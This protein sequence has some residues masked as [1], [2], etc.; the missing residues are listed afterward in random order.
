M[1]DDDKP[2]PS[3]EPPKLFGR[4]RKAAEPSSDPAP[5]EASAP[6]DQAPTSAGTAPVA[7]P[8]TEQ[9]EAP[10]TPAP[11]PVAEVA[12]QSVPE[13]AAGLEPVTHPD[14]TP[15]HVEEPRPL[16]EDEVAAE[17]VLEEAPA[18]SDREERRSRLG[19]ATRVLPTVRSRRS[20][21][22]PDDTDEEGTEPLDDPVTEPRRRREGPPLTGRPAAAAVGFIAGGLA[23]LLTALSLRLCELVRGTSACGSPGFLLLALIFAAVVATGGYLLRFLRVPDPFSTSFL[24]V[25]L[26]SVIALLFLIDVIL[27][28]PMIIVIPLLSAGLYVASH[29]VTTTFVEPSRD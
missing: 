22:G 29:W 17:P 26:T 23:V 21:Q 24:A 16:F 18:P 9:V 4:R 11:E 27:A 8:T 15:R 20:A 5:E 10:S 3:L 2:Q 13:P 7:E 6:A 12:P 25:G 14:P 28:W 1:V 19:R